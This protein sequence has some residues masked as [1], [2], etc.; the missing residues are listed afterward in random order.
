MGHPATGDSRQKRSLPWQEAHVP[1]A[2][3]YGTVGAAV[4]DDGTGLLAG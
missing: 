4:E 3:A 1:G 2:V